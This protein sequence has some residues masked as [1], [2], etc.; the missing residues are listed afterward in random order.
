[1]SAT[2]RLSKMRLWTSSLTWTFVLK[3]AV[4]SILTRFGL[5]S[6]RVQ[7]FWRFG[8]SGRLISLRLDMMLCVSD[9]ASGRKTI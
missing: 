1:M 7:S 8:G 2:S 5:P 9:I 4:I 3:R 6:S